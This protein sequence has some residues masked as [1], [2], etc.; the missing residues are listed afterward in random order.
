[1]N[2]LPEPIQQQI[3]VAQ[4]SDLSMAESIASNFAPFMEEVQ[5][6]IELL[7]PLEMGN[8]EH[9][10]VARRISIDLGRIRSR[11]DAIKKEQKD[12][13]LKVGRFIDALSNTVEGMI[14]LTQDEA[15]EHAK[16]FD[17]LEKQRIEKLKQDRIELISPYMESHPVGLELLN[18][19]TFQIM[20][21]GAKATHA[22]KLE[23]IRIAEE[24]RIEKEKIEKL[25]HERREM[26]LPI[27]QFWPTEDKNPDF[28]SMSQKDFKKFMADT[29][30]ASDL[31]NEEQAR[32]KAENERLRAEAEERAKAEKERIAREEAKRE[33]ESRILNLQHQR[34]RMLLR[35]NAHVGD[36][37][38]SAL[39]AM[40]EEDFQE[41]YAPAKQKYNELV[42]EQNRILH[43]QRVAEEQKKKLESASDKEKLLALIDDVKIDTVTTSTETGLEVQTE[44]VRKLDA[45]KFW[46]KKLINEAWTV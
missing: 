17:N 2:N 6:Q 19:E 21:S 37:I 18:E 15:K 4:I 42:A 40:S 44:L 1:M 33:E 31:Y 36:E 32:I 11:K 9:V 41:I 7:K 45:Y 10:E 13:Y 35:V 39:G 5:E 30:K 12:H 8:P 43:E 34:D 46:A 23:A 14:T 16:Y 24:Q 27:R 26:M 29:K 22:Q 28:G 25:H 3:A 38:I 20:L